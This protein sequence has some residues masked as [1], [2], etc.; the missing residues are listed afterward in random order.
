METLARRRTLPMLV[1]AAAT[2]AVPA[3]AVAARSGHAAH[4]VSDRTIR[5]SGDR[6]VGI[7]PFKPLSDR[8]GTLRGGIRAF[9]QPSTITSLGGGVGCDVRW[10]GLGLAARFAYFGSGGTACQGAYGRLQRATVTSRAWRTEG[11]L[12]VGDP[13]S[14]IRKRHPDAR[15]RNRNWWLH[16]GSSEVGGGGE[17]PVLRAVVSRGRVTALTMQVGAAGD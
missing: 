15:F 12:R 7:G 3:A 13:S 4:T 10:R 5:L 11:G 9:G 16:T 1:A 2:L 8:D 6:V 17:F 14:T